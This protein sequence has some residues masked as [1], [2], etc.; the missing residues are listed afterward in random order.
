MTTTPAQHPLA[1]SPTGEDE[2]D[3]RQ[4]AG[5]LSRRWRW[6]V[7]GGAIGVLFSGLSLLNTKP[8]YQGEFQIV[9]DQGNSKSAAAAFLSQNPALS[10]IAG[11]GGDGGSDSIA[12]EV[13]ILNSPSVLRP[14]FDAVKAQS[15]PSGQGNALSRL[16]NRRSQLKKKS[17]SVL[18]WNSAIP[19]RTWYCR[20]QR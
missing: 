17:T 20:S 5:A 19:T 4:V 1:A 11:L 16:S 13:Q 2:I 18:K 3:M 15:H 10:A 14:V 8:V 7:G 12:T 6:I 9:L